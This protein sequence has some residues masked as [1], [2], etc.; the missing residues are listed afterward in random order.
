MQITSTITVPLVQVSPDTST[1]KPTAPV[2]DSDQSL[3][4]IS[5]PT[6]S[7]LVEEAKSYPEVR[8]ELVA[9]YAAQVA[10]G[11]YPPAAVISGLAGLLS[12]EST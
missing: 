7:A 3:L 5:S 1:A 4:Q 8:S 11:H 12:G 10:S 2:E 9:A 6:F